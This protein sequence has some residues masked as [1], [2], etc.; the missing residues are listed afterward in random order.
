MEVIS[1]VMD[2]KKMVSAIVATA[3]PSNVGHSSRARRPHD[4]CPRHCVV[5]RAEPRSPRAG[6]VAPRSRRAATVI[7]AHTMTSTTAA[8]EINAHAR[9][10]LKGATT[11]RHPS[12]DSGRSQSSSR[13]SAM[14]RTAKASPR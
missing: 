9:F 12:G 3:Q 11:S 6:H 13:T 2:M 10:S 8:M 1:P 4:P 14:A 5:R 7:D